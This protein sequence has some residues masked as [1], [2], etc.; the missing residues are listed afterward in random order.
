MLRRRL[1]E[2]TNDSDD[3]TKEQRSNV[4]KIITGEAVG[5]LAIIDNGVC[6]GSYQVSEVRSERAEAAEEIK[7]RHASYLMSS[8]VSREFCPS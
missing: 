2:G 7:R 4:I 8:F 3:S 5:C 6:N 1:A